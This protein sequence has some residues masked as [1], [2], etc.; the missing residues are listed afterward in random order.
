MDTGTPDERAAISFVILC[1][2]EDAD[3][4]DEPV[5]GRGS[6]QCPSGSKPLVRWEWT[7]STFAP[8]GDAEG[9]GVTATEFKEPGEPVEA[10]WTSSTFDILGAVVG[11]ATD[12]CTFTDPS[13][14]G[15]PDSGN[16]ESCGP[17]S[18]GPPAIG[19]GWLPSVDPLAVWFVTSVAGFGLIV[20]RRSR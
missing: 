10:S 19:T 2:A 17:P 15:P 11:S 18:G 16:V 20:R 4:P 5:M 3:A 13:G 9:T 12:E 8:E 7:G 14:D 1:V 6:D